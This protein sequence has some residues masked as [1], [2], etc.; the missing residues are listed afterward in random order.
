M[1][2]ENIPICSTQ[3]ARN[4]AWE[5]WDFLWVF[6]PMIIAVAILLPMSL[7]KN[8]ERGIYWT[9][10]GSLALTILTLLLTIST[11]WLSFTGLILIS[12]QWLK[13]A[14]VAEPVG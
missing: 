13:L 14:E 9:R 7:K 2:E 4:T 3:P 11:C 1:P 10:A 5:D 8:A 6:E 12:A